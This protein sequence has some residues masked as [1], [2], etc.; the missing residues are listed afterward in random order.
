MQEVEF[1]DVY[2]AMT[3]SGIAKPAWAAF[4]LLHTHAGNRRLPASVGPQGNTSYISAMATTN[5]NG[6]GAESS[7]GGSANSLR[8]FLGFWGNPDPCC[9]ATARTIHI[10][11][12]QAAG[13]SLPTK[14]VTHVLDDAHGNVQNLWKSLGAP[15][16]PTPA[17]LAKLKAASGAGVV[18]VP[19]SALVKVNATATMVSLDV[20]ENTAVVVEYIV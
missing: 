18:P 13:S 15:N 20:T 10:T 19:A 5:I 12:N 1:L 16:K 2:G 17:Q 8:V 9:N 11:V 3:I 4:K 7:A 14:A 6:V